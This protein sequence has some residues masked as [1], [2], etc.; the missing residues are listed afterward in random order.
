[1]NL[2]E[3]DEKKVIVFGTIENM[4]TAF[5]YGQNPFAFIEQKMMGLKEV[6]DLSVQREQLVRIIRSLNEAIDMQNQDQLQRIGLS[7]YRLPV[8]SVVEARMRDINPDKIESQ[9]KKL[10]LSTNEQ[11]GVNQEL[12]LFCAIYV[13]VVSIITPKRISSTREL[14]RNIELKSQ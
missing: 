13:T 8:V 10:A 5:Q 1:M 4:Q 14:L 7:S 9:A 11:R 6:Q 3:T 12:H 2:T